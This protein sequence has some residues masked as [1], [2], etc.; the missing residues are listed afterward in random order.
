MIDVQKS[1]ILVVDD[2]PDNLKLISGLLKDTY[3]T[4]CSTFNFLKYP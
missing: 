3:K 2:T 4:R 1:T